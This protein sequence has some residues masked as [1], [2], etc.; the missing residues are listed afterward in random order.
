MIRKK[1]NSLPRDVVARWKI[2]AAPCVADMADHVHNVHKLLFGHLIV[3][4]PSNVS[5]VMYEQMP[6]VMRLVASMRDQVHTNAV[7]RF[8]CA[9]LLPLPLPLISMNCSST[10]NHTFLKKT[11][12]SEALRPCHMSSKSGLDR[13]AP[14]SD[15]VSDKPST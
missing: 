8:A 12:C 9:S 2:S 11:L 5:C 15:F 10:S 14:L 13:C 4:E 7:S 3:R 1:L 6:C